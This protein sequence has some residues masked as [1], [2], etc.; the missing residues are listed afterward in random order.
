MSIPLNEKQN[1]DE[2]T[3][4]LFK[5]HAAYNNSIEESPSP[6]F[7]AKLNARIEQAGVENSSIW[8]YGLLA[9]RRFLAFS[10]FVALLFFA[11]SVITFKSFSV[12]APSL[13]QEVSETS[14]ADD[15]ISLER[16][17]EDPDAV[18]EAR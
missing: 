1:L 11:T 6:F 9:T 18:E 15:I 17:S 12:S 14:N 3:S 2:F 13:G 8:E 16:L 4:E 10:G 5:A 7:M